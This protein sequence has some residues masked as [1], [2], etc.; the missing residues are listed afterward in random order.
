[1]YQVCQGHNSQFPGRGEL[2][3]HE[4]S[5][6]S[7]AA[8]MSDQEHQTNLLQCDELRSCAEAQIQQ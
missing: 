3:Q 2:H 7:V 4:L 1:M 8:A 6:V 5:D